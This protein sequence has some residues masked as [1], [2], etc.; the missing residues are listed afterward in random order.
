ME[1]NTKKGLDGT[2]LELPVNLHGNLKSASSDQSHL[3]IL[4]DIKSSNTPVISSSSLALALFFAF[5]TFSSH[6][7]SFSPT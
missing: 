5:K 7:I 2:G 6:F 4:H 3:Q 1:D